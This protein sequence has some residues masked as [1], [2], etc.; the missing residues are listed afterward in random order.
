MFM[1]VSLGLLATVRLF[2]LSASIMLLSRAS[3]DSPVVRPL[4]VVSAAR[5]G[6]FEVD[7]LGKSAHATACESEGIL[8]LIQIIESHSRHNS[9][10][11]VG[12]VACARD[13]AL[14]ASA[15]ASSSALSP[16]S[17]AVVAHARSSPMHCAHNSWSDT[18]RV[19]GPTGKRCT[20][21]GS[22][23]PAEDLRPVSEVEAGVNC[24][25]AG[26][27]RGQVA[28]S[29]PRRQPGTGTRQG[30]GG[31]VTPSLHPEV[32]GIQFVS[33]GY[34]LDI[35]QSMG[36]TKVCGTARSGIWVLKGNARARML[37]EN[38]DHLRVGW[39]SRGTY[40]TAWVTPGHDCLC[41]YKYGHG[42]AVRPQTNDAIRHGVIGLWSRVAPLLS[43]W[44]ARREVPTG[45]NLNRYS[46]LESH[47]LWHSDNER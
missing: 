16:A 2:G 36:C 17:L 28:G 27:V 6:P 34:G 21:G 20:K 39:I 42:A 11:G 23:G 19:Q 44:C 12:V 45:V 26:G 22:S 37:P 10:W 5:G 29:L 14:P 9:S 3:D 38:L 15:A 25:P 47:I 31:V 43:P 30:K 13:F 32:P 1:L 33:P 46:C 35:R 41:S 18:G 7:G 8:G 24:R 40:E 4:C